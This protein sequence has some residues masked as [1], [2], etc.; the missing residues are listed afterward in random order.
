MSAADEFPLP[1]GN[2]GAVKAAAAALQDVSTDLAAMGMRIGREQAGM[3]AA[4]QGDAA[5]AAGTETDALARITTDKGGRVGD[6]AAAL[7]DYGTA[8]QTAV[9]EV[10]A[11][12]RRAD[13]AE[14]DA[15]AEA[16]QS[17]QGRSYEDRQAIYAG[18]R[19]QRLAPLRMHYRSVLETLDRAAATAAGRLTA[20]V[21]EYRSGMT[22]GQLSLAARNAVA[23]RLPGVLRQDGQDRARDLAA[24]LQPLLE[25]GKQIPADLLANLEADKDNPWFAKTLLE[26]LGPQAPSWAM[27]VMEGN[28]FPRDYNQRV[29][30]D[31]G[32]LLAL[33]TRQEGDA[34]LS[35][36]Y[37]QEF[38]GPLDQHDGIGLQYAWHLGNLLHFGGRFG[39][40]FLQQAGD[41]LYA[42]DKEGADSEMYTMVGGWMNR[43][44]TDELVP[45][46]AME[47]YFDA[48]AKDADA[49]RVFFAGHADRLT[50]YLADRR[51]DDYLG[52][53]GD[54]LGRALEAAT[55]V[56]DAGLRGQGS[57]RVTSDLV[58]LLGSQ[59]HDFLVEHD[60]AKLLPHV[61][62]IL[63]GYREDVYYSLS[64][65]DYG[66][67]AATA[68]RLGQPELGTGGWGVE[69]AAADLTGTLAQLDHDSEAYKSVVRAQLSAS[70]EFLRD[71]LAAA[72]AEP[73]RRDELLQAYARGHGLVLKQL[74]DTHIDTQVAMGKLE[75]DRNMHDLRVADA[76][77]SSLLTIL[78]AFPP[79]A[80]P[81]TV[82]NV[83]KAATMPFLYEGVTSDSQAAANR[84]ASVAQ[85]DRWYSATLSTMVTTMQDG[86]GFSGTPAE[87][88]TWMSAH[89]VGA[90]DR[91]TDGGGHV[92]DPDRMTD[93]QRAA[94]QRWLA[95]PENEGVRVEMVKI[96]TALDAAGGQQ[97]G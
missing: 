52:D 51:T 33:S 7:S 48:V 76:V 73:G 43:P 23:L 47:A 66:C 36:A 18:I 83:G 24:Q 74:F 20:A 8:L 29:I 15:H 35:D 49:A 75:D 39:T 25:Q 31:F 90:A 56:H 65:T 2:P 95:D 53:G 72:R 37:V 97:R 78:P 63:N 16:A 61:A 92:L 96:F 54:A 13:Q 19:S 10:T 87:A 32:Q 82:L 45:D 85:V 59:D 55:S 3:A 4:W 41:K 5:T 14:I 22:P 79:A 46:D 9:A 80:I 44:L 88:G 11:I 38:L 12:R 71:K 64:R 57:A 86:G 84:S 1:P 26:T 94:Y 27:L 67:A 40:G 69:F 93:G 42:L 50:Y 62:D 91:F 6:G 68:P 21:P 60:R 77:S 17:S 34:R 30:T 70:E 58:H 81:A 89:G 28:G